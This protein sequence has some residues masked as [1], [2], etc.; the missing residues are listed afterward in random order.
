M[1]LQFAFAHLKLNRLDMF[2][3][4]ICT[5]GYLG[6]NYDLI[7]TPVHNNADQANLKLMHGH[8]FTFGNDIGSSD[9]FFCQ[10]QVQT[11]LMPQ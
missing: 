8:I 6:H 7:Q 2:S 3:K 11:K 4:K 5:I 1:T 9:I 10:K